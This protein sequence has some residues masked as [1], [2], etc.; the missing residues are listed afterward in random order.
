MVVAMPRS[1]ESSGSVA[2]GAA[3]IMIG[4]IPLVFGSD[5]KWANIAIAL[6]ILLLLMSV[7]LHLV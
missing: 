3:V 2:K 1:T 4:P 6:V 7:F 5:A